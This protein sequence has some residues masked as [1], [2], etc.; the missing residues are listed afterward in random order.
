M[1]RHLDY[2]IDTQG[3]DGAWSPH[4]SWMGAFPEAWEQAK[5]SWQGTLTVLRLRQLAAFGRTP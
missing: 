4:W 1:D 2:V 3:R 5:V